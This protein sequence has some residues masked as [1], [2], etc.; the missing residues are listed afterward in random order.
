MLF[1]KPRQKIDSD[2][3]AQQIDF[4]DF[5]KTIKKSHRFFDDIIDL[6]R[7]G[8]TPEER[9]FGALIE[10]MGEEKR[11][12]KLKKNPS[13]K[14]SKKALIKYSRKS[15]KKKQPKEVTGG[16]AEFEFPEFLDENELL[17]EI[18]SIPDEVIEAKREIKQA[19]AKIRD[20]ESSV[21]ESGDSGSAAIMISRIRNMIS[22][23]RDHLVRLNLEEAKSSYI[24][25]MKI[26]NT[27]NPEARAK[28]YNEINDFY[29]ERKSAEKLA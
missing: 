8:Q 18:R 26:Y 9:E 7:Q 4:S 21:I 11:G 22:N 28:V 10:R 13:S 15:N 3:D 19:S 5:D 24:E 25:I 17:S 29:F 23:A 20:T 2:K 27:L 14:K 12:H 16:G 1:F 6:G